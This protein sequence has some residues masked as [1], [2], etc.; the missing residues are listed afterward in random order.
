LWRPTAASLYARVLGHETF[1]RFRL[2][3]L[4]PSVGITS[5]KLRDITDH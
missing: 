4:D 3:P 1:G 2:A 5:A